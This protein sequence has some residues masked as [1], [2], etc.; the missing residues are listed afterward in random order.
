MGG[1]SGRGVS[2]GMGGVSGIGVSGGMG[3][4]SGTQILHIPAMRQL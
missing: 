1:V 2:G 4:I 3:S